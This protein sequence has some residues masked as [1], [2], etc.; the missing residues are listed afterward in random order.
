MKSPLPTPKFYAEKSFSSKKERRGFR[1]EKPPPT[2]RIKLSNTSCSSARGLFSHSSNN[3]DRAQS[4]SFQDSRSSLSS[5]YDSTSDLLYFHQCFEI[6]SKIGSGSFGDVFKVKCIED[7]NFYAVKRAK[8]KFAGKADRERKLQEVQKHEQLPYHPNCVRFYAAWEEQQILYIQIE[9]CKYSLSQYADENH[10]ITE[11]IVWNFLIDLLLA[12]KHLHDHNLVHL[13]IK[14]DNIFISKHNICKLGDFGLVLD[15]SKSD[16]SDAIE[17]DPRYLAPELMEGIFTKAA[18]VFSVGIT[19]LELASDLDLPRGSETWHQLRNLE[20]PKTFTRGISYPLFGVISRMMEPDYRKRAS[21]HEI[22]GIDSVDKVCKKRKRIIKSSDLKSNKLS[23]QRSVN[24]SISPDW[25]SSFSDEVFEKSSS[26]SF[27][28]LNDSSEKK[29]SIEE[30]VALNT[31]LN[32]NNSLNNSFDISRPP[33]GMSTPC[34]RRYWN[35]KCSA[36]ASPCLS[37]GRKKELLP[38]DDD[39]SPKLPK[40]PCLKLFSTNSSDEEEESITNLPP[41]NLLNVFDALSPSQ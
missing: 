19:I 25:G 18:D 24:K 12:V 29:L 13:D 15:L 34:S 22:L 7:G 17:G 36:S 21:V 32:L 20:I 8:Q 26:D 23:T 27:Y 37:G 31:S 2:P 1:S 30:Q 40:S 28:S 38:D 14:P 9:L 11:T 4:I 35:S 6:I 3:S 10:N 5:K 33:F 16:T 39:N 41:K